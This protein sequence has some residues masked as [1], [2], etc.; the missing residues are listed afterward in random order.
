MV[1]ID[2]AKTA[3]LVAGGV[4]ALLFIGTVW[5]FV[6]R[7]ASF[8]VLTLIVVAVAYAAYELQTGW[9][10]ADGSDDAT[11][12]DVGTEFDTV[13]DAS[14]PASDQSDVPTDDELDQELEQLLEQTDG[15]E[16]ET[17]FESGN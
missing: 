17:E 6:S 3:L 1:N 14:D 9:L 2:A 4:F 13:P 12:G 10:Q 16:A 15:T 8:A 7:L 11:S 5:R